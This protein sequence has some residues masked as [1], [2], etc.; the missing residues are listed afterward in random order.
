MENKKEE[1]ERACVA[2]GL[3]CKRP[4]FIFCDGISATSGVFV[5]YD[6]CNGE[7]DMDAK[8]EEETDFHDLEKTAH[9]VKCMCVGIE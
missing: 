6:E 3:C 9:A 4:V 7:N 2:H 8:S 5:F 1:Y